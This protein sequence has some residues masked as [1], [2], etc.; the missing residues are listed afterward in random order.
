MVR[1]GHSEGRDRLVRIKFA[2]ECFQCS[3]K[4]ITAVRKGEDGAVALKRRAGFPG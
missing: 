2:G 3:D 4:I 1:N